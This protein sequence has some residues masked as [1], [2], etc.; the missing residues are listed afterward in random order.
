MFVAHCRP[1]GLQ[2]PSARASRGV[3]TGARRRARGWESQARRGRTTSCRTWGLPPWPRLPRIGF[4]VKGGTRVLTG[5]RRRA[6]RQPSCGFASLSSLTVDQAVPFP[7]RFVTA[8]CR[9]LSRARRTADVARGGDGRGLRRGRRRRPVHGRELCSDVQLVVPALQS[10]V[11]QDAL[12][13]RGDRLPLADYWPEAPALLG[14]HVRNTSL[15]GA[16]AA[17]AGDQRALPRD[18]FTGV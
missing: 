14:N 11:A 16:D 12:E 8:R 7:S 1:S 17:E 6:R 4:G 5:R 9:L 3:P 13:L 10:E 2:P 18:G 15:P